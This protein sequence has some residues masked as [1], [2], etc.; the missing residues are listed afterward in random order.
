M[1]Q[2]LSQVVQTYGNA[3]DGGWKSGRL[4][5]LPVRALLLWCS[6]TLFVGTAKQLDLVCRDGE[7]SRKHTD[8]LLAGKEEKCNEYDWL[9]WMAVRAVDESALSICYF[10]IQTPNL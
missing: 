3:Y 8:F 1:L 2:V 4:Q 7:N 5:S 9:S 6:S 10:L